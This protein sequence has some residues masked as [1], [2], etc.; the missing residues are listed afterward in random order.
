MINPYNFVR[1]GQRMPGEPPADHHRFSGRSGLITCTIRTITPIF[2]PSSIERA[3]GRPADLDFFRTTNRPALPGSSLKGML[4]SLAE[5]TANGCSPFDNRERRLH[6]PCLS[7][8]RLCSVCRIFGYLRGREVHAGNVAIADALAEDGWQFGPRI[9]LK[10]LSGPKLRHD[11]FYNSAGQQRSRKFYYH[12]RHVR[13]IQDIPAESRPTH[14]NVT[15]IPLVHGTFR[16]SVRFWNLAEVDLGL[17]LH[18]LELPDGLYHKFGMGKPL[19]L[20]TVRIEIVGW[21]EHLP[22][23]ADPASR[24][25][26]FGEE[27]FRITLDDVEGEQ[28]ERARRL[29]RQCIDPLKEAFASQLAVTLGLP[30][31]NDLWSIQEPNLQDL[32]VML[33]LVSYSEDIR[34]PDFGWFKRH[35]EERLPSVQAIHGGSRL[36][37]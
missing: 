26:R 9:T 28:L 11:P 37:D 18:T 13:T 15:I 31:T 20:G 19:G 8:E 5:A 27:T 4:R 29:L 2:T 34:Y 23:P 25:K 6:S 33:S 1:S 14:R 10:E 7:R 3:P 35:S 16:F 30:P 24:Y 17:L 21:Q 12:Q 32:W 36:P 22:D